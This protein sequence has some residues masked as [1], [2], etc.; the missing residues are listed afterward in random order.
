M[1]VGLFDLSTL[2]YQPQGIIANGGALTM[3]VAGGMI[4]TGYTSTNYSCLATVENW[5]F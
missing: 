3:S 4:D 5:N 2:G 1:S